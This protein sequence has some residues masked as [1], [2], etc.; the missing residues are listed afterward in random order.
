ML[1]VLE[2]VNFQ[3][4]KDTGKFTPSPLERTFSA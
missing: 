2:D 4:S 1:A 3:W